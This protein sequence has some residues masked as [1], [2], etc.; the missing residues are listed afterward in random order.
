MGFFPHSRF[1]LKAGL[2]YLISNVSTSCNFF[3]RDRVTLSFRMGAGSLEHKKR[4]ERKVS[5]NRNEGIRK[6]LFRTKMKG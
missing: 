5:S 1:Q 6:G 2:N 3:K 4:Y